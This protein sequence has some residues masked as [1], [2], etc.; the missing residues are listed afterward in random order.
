[1]EPEEAARDKAVRLF[2]LL[3]VLGNGATPRSRADVFAQMASFYEGSADARERMFER[4]KKAL[5]ALGIV[6]ESLESVDSDE[7]I[8]YRVDFS[9]SQ[10]RRVSFTPEE[11]VVV[12]IA[13]RLLAETED[14]KSVNQAAL[15]I[16]ALAGGVAGH[17]LAEALRPAPLPPALQTLSNAIQGRHQVEFQYRKPGQE[18]RL[19]TVNP[20]VVVAQAGRWYLCGEDAD[21][22]EPRVFRVDRI[23]STISVGA[24]G[25]VYSVPQYQD[26]AHLLKGPGDDAEAPVVLVRAGCGLRVRRMSIETTA[27]SDE[28]DHCTLADIN[29][30]RLARLVLE[31]APDVIAMSPPSLVT[32]VHTMLERAVAHHGD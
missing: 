17:W 24:S 18:P 20:W 11:A 8:G 7:F 14:A 22:K 12:A 9:Q 5:R 19:R 16:D 31:H 6:I 4:D 27:Q 32:R 23:L 25:D 30:E 3:L 15:S 21:V 29:E 13:A 10:E 1:M 26:V 28:W 2:T